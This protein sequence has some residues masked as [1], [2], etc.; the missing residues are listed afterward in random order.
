[1]SNKQQLIHELIETLQHFDVSTE[2]FVQ[3]IAW[4]D[5]PVV[6]NS[7][8]EE[9][10]QKWYENVEIVEV[11]SHYDGQPFEIVFKYKGELFMSSGV[12][13]SWGDTSYDDDIV[14]CKAVEKTVTFY[15]EEK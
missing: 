14:P 9:E 4:E 7:E 5:T 2:E 15:E 8:L 1:M 10:F 3:A 6:E 13:S 12:Y 11:G